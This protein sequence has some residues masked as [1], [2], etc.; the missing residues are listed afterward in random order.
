MKR[1][2]TN[3][4]ALYTMPDPGELD[5][6]VVLRERVDVPADDFGTEPE[7]PVSFNAWAKVLQT[8]ATTYQETAQTDNAITHYITI[9]WRRG[10]TTDFEVA[11]GDEVYRVKRVRDLNS[12]RRFLLLECTELGSFT[13]N[14]GG[15]SSGGTLFSR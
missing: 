2:S 7:Y 6:R 8:S 15:I 10:I 13:E 11:N 12:K 1:R 9:R 4:S 3:T 14:S 5:Q